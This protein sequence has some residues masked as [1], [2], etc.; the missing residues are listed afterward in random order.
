MSAPRII[1]TTAAEP[2]LTVEEVRTYLRL[3]D[4]ETEDTINGWIASATRQAENMCGRRFSAGDYLA[5]FDS[6]PS[7]SGALRIPYTPISAI[8]SVG[9]VDSDGT[10]QTWDAENY[11]VAGLDDAFSGEIYLTPEG[12]WPTA[13]SR[14]NAVSVVFTAETPP[15]AKSAILLFIGALDA[16]RANVMVEP[17]VSLINTRAA[18]NLLA[19]Y[20]IWAL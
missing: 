20:R 2:V 8:T 17:N 19:P 5:T 10:S 15:D 12:S 9:Y 6:F 11:T 4:A 13:Y 14:P 1:L 7:A 3:D 16:V 18:E